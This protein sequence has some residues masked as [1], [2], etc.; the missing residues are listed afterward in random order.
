MD[1]VLVS[2]WVN[3]T[4]TEKY[5]MFDRSNIKEHLDRW[6]R[7]PRE[8]RSTVQ[9]PWVTRSEVL[10]LYYS[11]VVIY[12]SVGGVMQCHGRNVTLIQ[13]SSA[14]NIGFVHSYEDGHVQFVVTRK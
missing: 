8:R 4:I 1:E 11:G 6:N 3:S 9:N 2:G 5:V 13:I 7:L 10:S 12:F 14:C